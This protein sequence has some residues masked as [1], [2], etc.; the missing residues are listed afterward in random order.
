M[1]RAVLDRYAVKE[2][3]DYQTWKRKQGAEKQKREYACW[4]GEREFLRS[5]EEELLDY[6]EKRERQRLKRS[7]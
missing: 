2:P 7:R 5:V 6:E 3:L 1:T 4:D